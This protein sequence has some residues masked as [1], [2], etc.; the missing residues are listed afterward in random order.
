VAAVVAQT[1]A[2]ARDGGATDRTRHREPDLGPSPGAAQAFAQRWREGEVEAAFAGAAAVAEVE[3]RH[4]RLAPSPLEPR[5]AVALPDQAGGL[6]LYLSTQTP[7]RAA[8]IWRASC[9]SIAKTSGL[10]PPMSA[11]RSAARPHSTPRRFWSPSRRC[12]SAVR[13]GGAP[14]AAKNSSRP[15]MRAPEP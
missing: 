13:S 6:T 8:R 10:S 9:A 4:A 2:A 3:V 7:H 14:R 12:G 5:A 1:L 11:A 15:R